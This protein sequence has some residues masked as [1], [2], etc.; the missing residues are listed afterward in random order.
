MNTK[1][2][3][4]AILA[5]TF[6]L[7]SILSATGYAATNTIN[8]DIGSL[9]S[10]SKDNTG[11][12]DVNGSIDAADASRILVEYSAISTGKTSTL[13]EAEQ[14]RADVDKSGS[15]DSVDA[16][17]VLSYYAYVSTGGTASITEFLKDSQ[18]PAATTATSTTATTV[19]TTTLTTTTSPPP[20]T[21]TYITN[22]FTNPDT[23]EWYPSS[24]TSSSG[25]ISVPDIAQ[26]LTFRYTCGDN[27]TWRATNVLYNDTIH[28]YEWGYDGNMFYI[29][30]DPWW[31]VG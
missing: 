7:V 13:T 1:K 6:C 3:T 30:V 9:Y 22:G 2:L 20:I 14:K 4:S 12:I 28:V 8:T 17:Y 24:G 29:Y 19:P 27:G 15:I 21:N 25:N 31:L 23:G 16:S 18:Q 10:E 5:A 11:D 26:G